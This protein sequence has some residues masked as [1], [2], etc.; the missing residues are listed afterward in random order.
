MRLQIKENYNDRIINILKQQ[1]EQIKDEEL[2]DILSRG[3]LYPENISKN[4]ILFLGMNP[5]FIISKDGREIMAEPNKRLKGDEYLGFNK[6][7]YEKEIT[8]VPSKERYQTY[9]KIFDIIS[10]DKEWT[11][12]DILPFR[13]RNQNNITKYFNGKDPLILK[14]FNEYISISK[15]IIENSDPKL[16]IMA[17]AY[18]RNFTN[19]NDNK[20]LNIF[21]TKFNEQMGTHIII[22]G[23]LSSKPIFFT[24]MLSG[25]RALD[26]GSRERLIWHINSIK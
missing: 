17:N 23:P 4:K 20:H 7:L 22:N 25:Q 13:E 26:I 24:S 2:L 21:E 11:H 14:I 19:S 18:L 3:L 5:S 6:I 15:E 9:F 8:E 1:K 16:I 10:E 12:F